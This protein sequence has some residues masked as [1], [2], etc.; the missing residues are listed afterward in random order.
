[1]LARWRL[2]LDLPADRVPAGFLLAQVGPDVVGRV[3]IRF[4]LNEALRTH[5]GHIGFHV[6]PGFRRRGYAHAMLRQALV[7]ARAEGVHPALL[8]CEDDNP[9]SAATILAG[10]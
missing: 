8:T 4:T 6:R 3:S 10:G 5:G 2:G 9:A 1:M 7:V